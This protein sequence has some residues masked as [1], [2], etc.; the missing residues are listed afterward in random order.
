VPA[1]HKYEVL[2]VIYYAG[3]TAGRLIYTTVTAGG[4][5]FGLATSAALAAFGVSR[6]TYSALLLEAGDDWHV[7]CD[8]GAV[9]WGYIVVYIDVSPT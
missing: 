8:R 7:Y 2:E 1:G 5:G 6:Q 3:S 4:H 9:T